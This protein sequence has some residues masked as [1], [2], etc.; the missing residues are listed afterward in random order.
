VEAVELRAYLVLVNY[1]Q[2]TDLMPYSSCVRRPSDFLKLV[3]L[4]G[5]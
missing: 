1:Q 3:P 4:V 2:V 5:G